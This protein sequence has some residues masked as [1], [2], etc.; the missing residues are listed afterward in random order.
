MINKKINSLTSDFEAISFVTEAG[1]YKKILL[2]PNVN[3]I[4]REITSK[5]QMGMIIDRV[6]KL[7]IISIVK[8]GLKNVFFI[9]KL[10][11]KDF[12]TGIKLLCELEIAYAFQ[13]K[14]S[15]HF[16]LHYQMVDMAI[17]LNNPDIIR[18]FLLLSKQYKFLPGFMT[19]N[20]GPFINYV[21][22]I[23][24]VPFDLHIYTRIDKDNYLMNPPYNDIIEYLKN[25]QLIFCPI[26]NE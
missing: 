20:I 21:S 4:A 14:N 5:S 12:A 6:K 1:S 3:E 9:P 22:N 19:F 10:L 16:V 23:K 2:V 11:K 17:A 18:Y 24:D 15:N 13:R 25:S 26:K 7:S 8:V